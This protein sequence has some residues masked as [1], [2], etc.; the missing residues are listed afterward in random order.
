MSKKIVIALG[1]NAL[2][3]DPIEQLRLVKST[4]KNIVDL[5]TDGNQII[6][7]HGNGPQVG[8]INT[9]MEFAYNH[10]AGTPIIPFAECGAMSQGY[11]GYH[12]Q[13]AIDNELELKKIDKA[14]V[15]LITQVVVDKKDSAFQNPTKPVGLFYTKEEAEVFEKQKNYQFIDD[16]GRGYRRVVPSP[17]PIS[18]VELNIVKQLTNQ[19]TVVIT[20]GGGGIPVV[21]TDHG[22]KGIDAV[23]DKD[24]SSARL[25]IDLDADVL[26]ILTA[27][28]QVYLN[29]GSNNQIALKELSASKAREYIEQNQFSKG[30]ML[31]K[32]EACLDFVDNNPHGIAIITSLDKVKD[33]LDGKIGTKIMKE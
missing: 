26:L 2:G 25:A 8:M 13:Q 24:K 33:A 32:I 30:S 22:Y 10:E 23:I 14:C 16:A 1:G 20:I 5:I 31:P 4:A 12:L 17:R 21:K 3:K 27:V 15:T 9:G 11:I 7:S 6:I 28:G 19:G 18:I 29:Y